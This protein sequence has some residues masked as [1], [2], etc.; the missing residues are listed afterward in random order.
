MKN[1]TLFT[2]MAA[3]GTAALM[4][5][6]GFTL[7]ATT[8]DTDDSTAAAAGA[9]VTDKRIVKRPKADCRDYIECFPNGN[10]MPPC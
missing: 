2:R 10:C 4:A 9:H 3:V 1:T 6:G 7:A 8:S 5:A